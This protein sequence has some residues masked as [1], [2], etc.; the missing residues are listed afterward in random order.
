M[1]SLFCNNLLLRLFTSVTFI[2]EAGNRMNIEIYFA[3]GILTT[4]VYVIC[5]AV[6]IT[7]IRNKALN[8]DSRIMK[9]I[10]NQ[11]V[12]DTA[13]LASLRQRMDSIQS[14]IGAAQRQMWEYGIEKE[15]KGKS[16]QA[17]CMAI[18]GKSVAALQSCY[19]M[20]ETDRTA[21]DIYG[22]I[23]SSLMTVGVIEIRPKEGDEWNPADDR[24]RVR[25]KIGDA[26]YRITKL[27]YPG[28]KFVTNLTDVTKSK[29]EI[30]LEPAYIDVRGNARD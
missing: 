24:F 1:A 25:N 21:K 27:V 12:Q 15:E 6:I 11:T 8:A 26:P 14:E 23:L 19:L 18:A 9:R 20:S 13:T 17:A 28:Y 22:E 2:N 4:M 7:F 3:I 29:S 5:L 30:I 10:N 16:W